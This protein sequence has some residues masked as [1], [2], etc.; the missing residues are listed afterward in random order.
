MIEYLKYT[1]VLSI[2]LNML[3]VVAFIITGDWPRA[4][5]W[6]LAS[7]LTLTTFFIK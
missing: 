1:P 5:Y 3:S 6:G 2:A 7:G 4:W